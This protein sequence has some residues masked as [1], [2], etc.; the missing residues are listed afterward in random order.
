[1]KIIALWDIAPCSL[2]EV[3]RRFRGAYCLHHHGDY[4]ITSADLTFYFEKILE[5]LALGLVYAKNANAMFQRTVVTGEWINY[6][7]HI[8]QLSIGN[9]FILPRKLPFH[10]KRPLISRRTEVSP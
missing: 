10:D 7:T 1:L 6:A 2:V 8:E 3:D 4:S 5:E 9:G